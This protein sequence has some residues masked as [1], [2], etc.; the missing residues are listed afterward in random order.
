M[1]IM[2]LVLT[3]F[4]A[5]FERNSLYELAKS[6]MGQQDSL[7]NLHYTSVSF[8]SVT[9]AWNTVPDAVNYRY[10]RN[11][12]GDF[13]AVTPMDVAGTGY[14]DTGLMPNTMYYF[15]VCAS[16]SDGGEECSMTLSLRTPALPAP[17]NL[18]VDSF[19]GTS[20]SISWDAAV[21]I[22][23]YYVYR[24]PTIGIPVPTS[25]TSYTDSSVT[26]G[27]TYTY[28]VTCFDPM[29]GEGPASN[30]VTA[31]PDYLTAPTDA[32]T[33]TAHSAASTNINLKW[34]AVS[35]ALAYRV[36]RDT[37]SG[38]AFA[39]QVYNGPHPYFTDRNL[40]SGTTYYYR[41]CAANN[42]GTGP[43]SGEA[44]RLT[45]I[46]AF[47][48]VDYLTVSSQSYTITTISG[49]NAGNLLT[50]GRLVYYQT[51]DGMYGLFEVQ[52]LDPTIIISGI[53]L[54]DLMIRWK[55]WNLG[56]G[57]VYS[58][59]EG[60]VIRGTWLCDLDLGEETVSTPPADF[61]WEILSPTSRQI[62]AVSGAGFFLP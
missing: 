35:N 19:T 13:T 49:G 3:V 25:A 42:A 24:D 5:C 10:F 26:A 37:V 36:Y 18:R 34:S 27:T 14:T 2:L 52:Q 46:D 50:V 59:G 23:T 53:E 4:T 61:F 51:V 56:G 12:T 33:L 8:N 20:V 48:A 45:L 11:S 47:S 16:Y 17:A 7:F 38:G 55:T 43:Y 57:G 6:A 29:F 40:A 60:L 1:P 31:T 15:M 9:L 39:T 28:H 21:G 62:T 41:V 22:S 30:T 44:S 32:P 54:T 58:Q